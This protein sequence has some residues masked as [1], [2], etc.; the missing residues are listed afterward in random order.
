MYE[1]AHCL[2]SNEFLFGPQGDGDRATRPETQQ[3]RALRGRPTRGGVVPSL[4]YVLGYV[5]VARRRMM[6]VGSQAED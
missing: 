3:E 1:D 5:E 4:E 6:N 2:C